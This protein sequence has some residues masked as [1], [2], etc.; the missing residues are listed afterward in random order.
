MKNILF[1]QCAER[2]LIPENE[3]RELV[4]AMTSSGTK[5]MTVPDLCRICA[6][7]KLSEIL[8]GD[9]VCHVVACHSRAVKWLFHHA[10]I[11]SDEKR[12][13]FH[14]LRGKKAKDVLKEI[15]LDQPLERSSDEMPASK[16]NEDK[17]SE[18]IPWFPVIDYDLCVNCGECLNFCLFGVYSKSS[19]G[20]I[21]V[22][23]PKNCKTNCPACERTCP[24]T[25]IIFP[26]HSSPPINGGEGKQTE[27]KDGNL[28]KLDLDKILDGDIYAKLYARKN[29]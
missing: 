23:N 1:C 8:P 18:W 11:R 19:D 6:E 13:V 5:F 17:N 16:N 4:D 12:F 3:E 2:R 24:K 26:K 20:K 21:L 15:E 29:K 7:K 27:D 25:A 22:A 28:S 10:G 14:D 9:K